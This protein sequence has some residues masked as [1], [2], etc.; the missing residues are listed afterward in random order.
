MK[1]I[2]VWKRINKDGQAEYNHHED[3]HV[4]TS[5]PTPKFPSQA[6]WKNKI[7]T[8]VHAWMNDKQEII[9]D[10]RRT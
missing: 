4:F 6:S 7:W 10:R 3:G 9:Y 1:P 2:T 5:K 8:R